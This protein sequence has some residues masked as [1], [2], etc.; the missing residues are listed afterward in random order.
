M[1]LQHYNLNVICRKGK[2]LFVEVTRACVPSNEQSETVEEDDVMVVESQTVLPVMPSSAPN[3]RAP[4]TTPDFPL[5]LTAID[6]FQWEGEESPRACR[7][8]LW[9]VRRRPAPQHNQCNTDNQPET[10]L[11][12]PQVTTETN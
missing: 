6:I 1:I 4:A 3:K 8:L 11:C 5:S 2:Q 12:H 10:P 9:L 7:F